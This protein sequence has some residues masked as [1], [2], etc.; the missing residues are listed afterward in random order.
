MRRFDKDDLNEW[1]NVSRNMKRKLM[2]KVYGPVITSLIEK[3]IITVY[4]GKEGSEYYRKGGW[5][6]QADGSYVDVGNGE[7]GQCK[8]YRLTKKWV[9]DIR[10][11]KVKTV[12]VTMSATAIR[13]RLSVLQDQTDLT[14]SI[15]VKQRD[16]LA[17]L[18]PMKLDGLNYDQLLCAIKHEMGLFDIKR[19]LDGSQRMYGVHLQSGSRYV[20]K[21]LYW[22]KKQQLKELDMKSAHPQLIAALLEGDERKRYLAWLEKLQN[23]GTDLYEFFIQ[24]EKTPKARKRMKRIFEQAISGIGRGPDVKRILDYFL[25]NFPTLWILIRSSG[26]DGNPK[27]QMRLQQIESSVIIPAFEE[28][29]FDICIQQHDCLM[30]RDC[31]R[32]AARELINKHCLEKLGYTIPFGDQTGVVGKKV[33][34]KIGLIPFNHLLPCPRAIVRSYRRRQG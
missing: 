13:K 26:V 33:T 19:G 16:N 5:Q 6:R 24:G 31:D 11:G 8:I 17:K 29:D 14:D 34:R 7:K 10:K 22:Y 30:I 2:G 25:K 23:Q 3:G 21:N 18:D 9:R 4:R 20:A 27:T 12:K 15:A 1:M 32:E 28:A